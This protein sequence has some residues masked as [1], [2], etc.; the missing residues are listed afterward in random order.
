[1][2]KRTAKKTDEMVAQERILCRLDRGWRSA[3]VTV[4]DQTALGMPAVEGETVEQ[5]FARFWRARDFA[6]A[7][8]CECYRGGPGHSANSGR[9]ATRPVYDL[10]HCG[11]ASAICDDC[12]KHC[13]TCD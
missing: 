3:P 1:M 6:F 11:G 12:R 2:A 9:C 5:F 4:A 13:E 7:A 10:S 8:R